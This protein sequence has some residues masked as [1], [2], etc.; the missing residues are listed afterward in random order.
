MLRVALRELRHHPGRYLA[1]LIAIA[2]SV[3][4]LAAASVV[5][6]TES[7]AMAKQAGAPYSKADLV[8]MMS[9]ITYYDPNNEPDAPLTDDQMSVLITEASSEV[10]A[11]WP[12]N[13]ASQVLQNDQKSA[14]LQIY[15][16][17]PV[18]F[19]ST[20]V[21][22]PAQPIG[23]VSLAANAI[24]ID[25]STAKALNAQVGTMLTVWQDQNLVVA[26]I[27]NEPT[28][29]YSTGLGYVAPATMADWTG[30]VGMMSDTLISLK[31]GADAAQVSQAVTGALNAKGFYAPVL[32]AADAVT[33]AGANVTQG[34]DVFKYFIWVFAGIALVVG[35]I[36]VANTFAIL[37]TQRRRQL[38]LL[39][40]IGASGAQV[41][42][43]IWAEAAVLGLIGSV[44]GVGLAYGLAAAVGTY[45]G[46][47]HFGFAVPWRALVIAV[48]IGVA[49]T[50]LASALPAN[51]ATSL[52]VLDA[53]RPPD[54]DVRRFRLPVV[55]TVICG[56]LFI[57]GVAACVYS[58]FGASST[59]T[60]LTAVAGAA[61]VSLGVL[62]GAPLFVPGLL[63]AVGALVGKAGVTAN[64]AVKNTT[65]DPGRSS[66]TA[67]A[68]MLAVGLIVTLQVGA[69]TMQTTVEAKIASA[70]PVGLWVESMDLGSS[71][72][73]T[74]QHQLATAAGITRSLA[75]NCRYIGVDEGAYG[76]QMLS[77]CAYDTGIADIAPGSPQ[78]MPDGQVLVPPGEFS[79]FNGVKSITLAS[80]QTDGSF[81]PGGV[82]VTPQASN[83]VRDADFLLVSPATLSKLDG[84][85]SP[86]IQSVMLFSVSNALDAA[87]AFTNLLVSP[88]DGGVASDS[89]LDMGGS[90]L[91]R[92][93]I[94]QVLTILVDVMTGLLAVAVLIALVGV[95]S[96]LTLSV[97][98][99]T[100]ESAL[101]RALGL[102]RRQLR[103]M[104]LI[105]ALML[106]VVSALVGV[107][108]GAFFGFVGAHAIVGQVLADTRT[109][110]A[111]HLG[112]N[113]PQTLMLLGVLV[114]AAALASVLPG[115]RAAAAS[116]V[117][118][119]A[120]V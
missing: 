83:L 76:Q 47:I 28:S 68:L 34:I 21:G 82:A 20:T 24:L 22:T 80:L 43:S 58:L 19:S 106:T 78:S 118:A 36:T 119:L 35:M 61:L 50:V 72:P 60:L 17:P 45:T 41:R 51:R 2:I 77:V 54:A 53:L 5:T 40:A 67:T 100:R 44:V 95:S 110:L 120:E 29:L 48:A 63:R 79:G 85:N 39:R 6:A 93:Q 96:T 104:L 49:I 112:I 94:E 56:L 12:L 103:F 15:A 113:W 89:S 57:V 114:L 27:T 55:R 1:I 26:G 88:S 37:L 13:S 105:E 81:A 42:H 10:A 59:R 14:F 98:E 64:T 91:Q 74:T 111:I 109:T 73:T 69:S 62:F 107:L 97:V 4:F 7:Q 115:R 38:G 117:E 23:A 70:Y 86:E 99:R 116:P 65:R 92:Q 75:L 71:I 18:E 102:R 33:A 46:S 11:T 30:G 108:F 66:A 9:Q 31:P 87:T 16:Q 3:G 52:P 25:P 8:V 90:A 32:N 84:A 101:L